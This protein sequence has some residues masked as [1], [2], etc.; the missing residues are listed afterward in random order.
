MVG[1]SW[2]DAMAY[3]RWLADLTGDP[4]RL[5]SEAEWEKGARGT[6]GRTYPWGD[7]WDTTR[8]NTV[9][10]GR[11]D[12]T[13]VRD[14]PTGASPYG[15]LDVAGNVWEWTRTL[16]GTDREHPDYPYP[17]DRSDGREDE[18]AGGDVFRVLRGGAYGYPAHWSRCASRDWGRPLGASEYL[19]FRVCIS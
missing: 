8:C 16:L 9:E 2:H 12:T 10:S 4:V 1:V 19:G 17:Y 18:S 14:H 13:S 3:C 5:P 6:D 11:G 7:R 15:V